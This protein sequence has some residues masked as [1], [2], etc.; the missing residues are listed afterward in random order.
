MKLSAPPVVTAEMLIRR[1]VPEVFEAFADPSITTRFWFTRSTGRLEPGRRVRWS[2]EMYGVSTDVTVLEFEPDHR[3]MIEWDQPTTRVEWLFT[4]R[5][6]DATHVRIRQDGFTGDA[7]DIV[8]QAIDSMGGFSFVL[9]GAKALLEHGVEL[10]LVADHF[11]D[12]YVEPS[13]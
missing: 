9:A 10:N 4:P 1:P 7:D 12:S 8:K 3:I 5:S 2:W 11:P 6:P 13:G